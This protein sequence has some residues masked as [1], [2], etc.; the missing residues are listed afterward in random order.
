MA[1]LGSEVEAES[2][3]ITTYQDN[4]HLKHVKQ[5]SDI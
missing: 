4:Y 3:L 2:S 1:L 5:A